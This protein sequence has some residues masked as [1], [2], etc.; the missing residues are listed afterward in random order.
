MSGRG[1]SA[2]P[3]RFARGRGA[4]ETAAQHRGIED[5][6]IKLGCAMPG[7]A[8]SGKATKNDICE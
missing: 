8:Q 6:R 1:K 4:G 3:P 2:S 5:R 7:E